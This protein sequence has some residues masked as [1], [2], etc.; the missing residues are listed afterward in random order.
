MG[1]RQLIAAVFCTGP[2]C[3]QTA[4]GYLSKTQYGFVESMECKS[5]GK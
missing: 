1:D 3:A 5:K 4:E 2:G